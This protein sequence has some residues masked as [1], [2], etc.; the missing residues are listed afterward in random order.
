MRIEEIHPWQLPRVWHIL[1]PIIDKA[2][3]HSLGERMASDMLQD[4][5]NDN[6]WLLTAIDDEGDL[7][8]VMVAEEIV[9]PQKKELYVHVW[10]TVTGYGYDEWAD[11]CEQSLIGIALDTG[12]HYIA[13]KCR[14]GLARKMVTKHG[15]NETYSVVSKQVPME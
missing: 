9:Y 13:T 11:L 2:L 6:L 3:D 8:G 4:F 14:K 12:C 15:W 5:M 10:A 7:A 1:R